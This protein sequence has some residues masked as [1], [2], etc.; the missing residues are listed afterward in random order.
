[1][2]DCTDS[3]QSDQFV[4]TTKEVAEYV[5]RTYRY[6]ADVRLAVEKIKAPDF[7]KPSDPPG[8][9]SRTAIHVWEKKV[10]EYVKKESYFDENMKTLYSLIWGQCTDIMRTKL[11]SLNLFEAISSASD[12]L[13]L[14]K[15]IKNIVFNFQ[16]QK[17]KPQALHEAKRQLFVLQQDRIMT[18]QAFLEQYQNNIGWCHRTLWGVRPSGTNLSTKHSKKWISQET[19]LRLPK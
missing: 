4:K 1:V 7:A 10:D 15:S 16:S 12:A 9:A 17:Y 13:A 8:D 19:Q 3:L 14:L 11:E 5:G 2:Y 18:A 6:G